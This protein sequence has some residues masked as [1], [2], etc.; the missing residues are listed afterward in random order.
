MFNREEFYKMAHSGRK[1]EKNEI[2]EV[3]EYINTFSHVVIWG[4]SFLGKAVGKKLIDLGVNIENY[5]D[6]RCNEISK[7]NGIDTIMPF[8]TDDLE[9]T[10]VIFCI[11]NNVIRGQLLFELDSKGYKY[12]LRGD[13]LYEGIVCEF[14]NKTGIDSK[15]C[16]GSMCCRA[17]FC[18]RLDN[19]VK[20]N[21]LKENH[22]SIFHVTLTINQRC[23]LKC[24]CCTS[25]MNEYPV[26]DRINIPL[27]RIE[28]DIDEFFDAIDSVG[29]VT[30][31]GGEPFMHPDLALIVKKLLSKK[32]IGLICIATSG[33]FPIKNEQLEYLNDKRVNVSFSNYEPSI[34]EKLRGIMH[35]SIEK[36]K[37]SGIAYTVGVPMPEWIVPSTLYNK[38]MTKE[39][40]INKK[41]NCTHNP[42]C[43]MIKNGKL[44]PCDFAAAV[45][46]LGIADYKE[47]YIE[48]DQYKDSKELKNKIIEFIDKPYY[49]VCGHCQAQ[50][51]TAK[52]AEQGYIDFKKQL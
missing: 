15:V 11:G 1:L 45:Y 43:M 6:L 28:K 41:Q 31:M 35:Q 37:D 16:Q 13:Y 34:S 2:A 17:M 33:T 52:A 47:D 23:S 4:A 46:N 36:V 20:N 50:G 49:E 48:F 18:E 40:L 10:L 42:R 29:S 44:H 7:V 21:N 39:Q 30:V 51:K 22:F 14:D 25:Y 24:K 12:V 9:N 19:I 38:N 3:I 32:N 5:W 26:K 8:T 27:S